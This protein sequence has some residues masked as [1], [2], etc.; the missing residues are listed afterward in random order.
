ML[1]RT[2]LEEDNMALQFQAPGDPFAKQKL[3]QEQMNMFNQTIS[4]IGQQALQRRQYSDQQKRQAIMDQYLKQENDRKQ[5][6]YDRLHAVVPFPEENNP[7]SQMGQPSQPSQLTDE[8][9]MYSASPSLPTPQKNPLSILNGQR[10]MPQAAQ[11]MVSLHKQMYPHLANIN[12]PQQ[13]GEVPYGQS[14]A[15]YDEQLARQF[16]QSEIAKNNSAANQTYV[17]PTY[18]ASGN[19]TGYSPIPNGAKPFGGGKP[20]SGQGVN[21]PLNTALTKAKVEL[22]EARP[23]VQQILKEIGR[24]KLLNA[25]SYGGKIGEMEYKAKSAMNMGTKDPKFTNT[26]DI[27]NTMQN[28]VSRVLKSTFGGQLSDSERAYL[29]QVY[30][31]LPGLSQKEREIA[32]T[33]VETMIQNKLSGAESKYNELLQYTNEG[34]NAQ[35]NSQPQQSGDNDPLGIR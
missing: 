30:G 13:P 24:V 34:P 26:A 2:C 8:G 6:E 32:M 25:N 1:A 10:G 29:N 28:Q 7:F 5:S 27:L 3:E 17:I 4:G 19:V 31:A 11:D 18:D 22:A 23:M 12:Q 20:I 21:K 33:N 9:N 35:Y 14:P 15:S 16:K